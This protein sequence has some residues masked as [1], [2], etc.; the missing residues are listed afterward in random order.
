MVSAPASAPQVLRRE[1]LR[2][3]HRP[4]LVLVV[5]CA[6][7]VGVGPISILLRFRR[8][9]IVLLKDRRRLLSSVRGHLRVRQRVASAQD[10]L[11]ACEVSGGTQ[12]RQ[13]KSKRLQES[14]PPRKG[15]GNV[16]RWGPKAVVCMTAGTPCGEEPV[17]AYITGTQLSVL[18]VRSIRH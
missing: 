11:R 16:K 14:E 4:P 6:G 7:S 10:V 17:H 15:S 9:P 18:V 3:S 12:H 1:G 5:T 8:Q 2:V 13:R